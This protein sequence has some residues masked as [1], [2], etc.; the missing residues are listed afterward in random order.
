M[1]LK[2]ILTQLHGL[3]T[4]VVCSHHSDGRDQARAGARGAAISGGSARGR[5]QRPTP[6]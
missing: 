3:F 1:E 4:Y 2:Y 5:Q 6:G